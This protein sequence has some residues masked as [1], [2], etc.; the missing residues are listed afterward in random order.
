MGRVL[1]VP[2]NAKV[3]EFRS[4]K[5]QLIFAPLREIAPLREKFALDVRRPSD[6]SAC[7]VAMNRYSYRYYYYY[8]PLPLGATVRRWAVGVR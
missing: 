7:R 4:P 6:Y 3:L 8:G 5:Q 2:A 1:Q